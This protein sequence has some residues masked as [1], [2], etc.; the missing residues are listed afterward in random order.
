MKSS[1]PTP[2]SPRDAKKPYAKP[3]LQVYGRLMDVTQAIG[4][5]GALDANGMGNAK[6]SAP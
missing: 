2:G 6:N 4:K 3:E 5:S 1:P